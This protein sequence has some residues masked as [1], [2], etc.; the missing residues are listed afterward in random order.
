MPEVASPNIS[1][2]ANSEISYFDKIDVIRFVS[3]MMVVVFHSYQGWVNKMGLPEIMTEHGDKSTLTTIGKWIHFAL[4]NGG[5][6]VEIF[7]I[8]SGFLITYLL[9]KEKDTN[10]GKID[11]L[12]FYTRRSLRIW[13]LYYLIIC[14]SPL[15]INWVGQIEH[16]NYVAN[17]FFYNN[18]Y[19]MQNPDAWLFPLAH[20]WTLCIEEHFYIVWPLII[21]FIPNKYLMRTFISLILLSI[22]YRGYVF[23]N[24][25]EPWYYLFMSTFSRYD[26]LVI[27]AVTAYIH[28]VRPIKLSTSKT[29]RI[30]VYLILL[31]AITNDNTALWN[32][33]F[34]ACFKKYF[35]LA[36][37]LFAM[38]NFLF[39]DRP[40]FE[41]LNNRI[42]KYLGK[43]SFGIYVYGLIIH[44][45][46]IQKLVLADGMNNVGIYWLLVL[47]CSLLIPVIS[48]ELFEKQFLK[49]KKRF[50]VVRIIKN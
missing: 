39:N 49:L 37:V 13:P 36:L 50:E 3:A 10:Q 6:G 31:M 20:F 34:M 40:M 25:E 14:L 27:G 8:I 12:K 38:L 30:V 48:Y 22:V 11:L 23:L 35:Y 24:S 9:L 42:I 33:L 32:D 18:F 28:F 7:F 4:M 29:L 47:S 2:R 45:L 17:I 44:E 16:P 21:A 46:V 43:V 1:L 5:Y 19:S 41:F 26:A 15:I